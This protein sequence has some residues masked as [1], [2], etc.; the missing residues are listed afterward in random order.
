MSAEPSSYTI[1]IDQIKITDMIFTDTIDLSINT[2]KATLAGF[3]LKIACNPQFLDILEVLPGELYDSCQW[4]F[5]NARQAG[6]PTKEK[7]PFT[8]WQIVALADM[9]VDDKK[10]LCFSLDKKSTLVRLVISNQF[11]KEVPDTV[12]PIFFLWE[13][14]TDN[15]ISSISGNSLN[16]SN[17]VIESF[18]IIPSIT[19]DP[20][21]SSKGTSGNCIKSK[22]INKPKRN[23]DF[24]NGGIM[25]ELDVGLESSDTANRE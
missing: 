25:F 2:D 22:S 15:T 1:S 17:K 23:I 7:M 4:D 11:L 20:F 13:D 3:D 10:P 12:V 5:F 19:G 8:I 24:Y 16:L 18:K 6:N 9:T 21:P 14:C